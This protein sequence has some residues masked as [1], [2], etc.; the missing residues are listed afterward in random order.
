MKIS[1]ERRK[2]LNKWF[3]GLT[4][5]KYRKSSTGESLVNLRLSIA[6]PLRLVRTEEVDL[7][8]ASWRTEHDI[9][10]IYN[11]HRGYP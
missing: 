11:W 2:Q 8:K 3:E 1:E 4:S 10:T 9:W 7:T 6:N 5:W